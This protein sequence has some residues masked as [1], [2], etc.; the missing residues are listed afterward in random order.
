M[1][2]SCTVSDPLLGHLFQTALSENSHQV[3]KIM[4]IILFLDIALDILS[5]CET[6][7]DNDMQVQATI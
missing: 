2:G 1:L 5:S 3:L 6:K 4:T 7:Y